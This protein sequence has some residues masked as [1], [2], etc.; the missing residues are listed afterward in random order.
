MTALTITSIA[1]GYDAKSIQKS[2]IYTRFVL[3]IGQRATATGSRRAVLQE[4]RN[5]RMPKSIVVDWIKITKTENAKNRKCE[6]PK[7]RK[8]KNAKL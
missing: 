5:T 2:C 1:R 8:T 4:P 7:M 3:A 6:K